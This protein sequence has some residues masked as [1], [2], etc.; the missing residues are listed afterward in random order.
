MPTYFDQVDF[1]ESLILPNRSKNVITNTVTIKSSAGVLN[2]V[3][4]NRVT[5]T[6]IRI[7]DT[8]TI[9]ST[10]NEVMRNTISHVIIP[11]GNTQF[12]VLPYQVRFTRGLRVLITTASDVTFSFK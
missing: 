5:Q 10:R 1:G 8:S 6:S 4:L 11:A 12:P 9:L 2:R 3:V 7:Y